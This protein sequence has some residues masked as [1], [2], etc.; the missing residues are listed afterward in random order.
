[1]SVRLPQTIDRPASKKQSQLSSPITSWLSNLSS[2]SDSVSEQKTSDHHRQSSDPCETT[3]LVQRCVIIQKDQHGFGFTVSGDRIVL[4]QSVRPGGAAMKAGVKEGDRIIKVN[5]TMVTNSSHL[6]VV[7]LIKSGAYVA[8]TLLGSSTSSVGVSGLQEDPGSLGP[9]RVIPVVPPPPPPPPPPLPQRITGPKPLQDPEVQKHA[10]QILINMLR[11]EEKELQHFQEMYS[12]NPA[13]SLLE[14][15]I[16]GARRRITQLQRK[17]Q[18]ETGVSV[19]ILQL[20]DTNPA[21]LKSSEGCHFLDSQDGDSGLDSGTERFPSLSESLLKR[22]SVLSDPGLDSPRTSP[23]IMAKMPQH[24]RRQGSDTTVLPTTEQSLDHSAKPLIIGPEEDYDP[25]YFNNECDILFQDLEKLKYRPAHLGVFLRYI[26]SQADPNPLLFYLCAEVYLQT[27]PK[28][29]RGLGKAIWAIFLEKNSPLRVKI[30]ETLQAEI[31]LRLR[32]NEDIRSALSE[33]QEATMPEIQEQ[34]QDYRTKR[35]MGLG[36]LYGENDL[37][38]LDGDPQRER[39]IA[40]RQLAALGDILSK[41][42][43]DRSVSMDF[44][45]NTYMSHAGIRLR[46]TRPSTAEKSQTLPDKDKWLPFFPKTKKQSSNTKKEKEALEDKKRNPIL[47]YI[48][49]PK[50]SSQNI[51]PGNVRNII[52]HFENNQ[53]HESPEPGLQRLSTGS[54]PEDLLESESSRSEIRLGRSESL[55]GREEMKKSRKAEN[56]PRSRS[57]VDMDAAAEATRLHQSASSSASSLSTRSLENPTPPFTPK[58]GRRSI[59]S[60]SLG[61]CTDALLPHLLEDDL[62]QLSDLEPEPDAQN[63]QHTVGKDVIAGLSQREID[64]QEVINELFV[65][66]AS[67]LRTLR[68]LD[69]IFYQRMKKENLMPR[70]ELARLFPN[71]PELIEIHNSWCEAMKKLREEGPVIN[72]ISDLMLARFDGP[73]REELQQVAAQFCS[74]QSIALELI[75]TKQRKESRFQLFMQEAESNPQ[76]RRLQLK[77]LI[78][79]E[80][81]RLTKYPLLLEN[82]IKYTDA[83]SS[84][85]YHKLC[86]ARDQCREILKYVN[87]AVKQTENRHR[88]ESYQKRLDTTSLER[89]SNPLAAE[90][91]SLDLTTRRMIHEGPLTWRISKDKTVDLHVLLLEDL[92][93]LLQKQD[94]KLLLKC[95]SKTSLGSS[96]NK[97]TFSPVLKLNAVLIRS[98]ATDK[99]AFFIICTSELGPPQI[100]ELVA[101]T[102]LDKNM[103]MELLEDAVQNATRNPSIVPNPSHLSQPVPQQPSQHSSSSTSMGLTDS[104][105]SQ[106]NGCQSEDELLPKG[107]RSQQWVN[108]K[109]QAL[110]EEPEQEGSE[111]ELVAPTSTSSL[112]GGGLGIRTRGAIHLPL[113]SPLFMEGLADSA[114]EDVENLRHLILWSL[115]PGHPI[116]SRATVEPED[117]LTPTPSVIGI[118]SHPWDPGSPG[119]LPGEMEGNDLAP[120][121]QMSSQL[122]L[123]TGELDDAAL[124]SLEHLPPR[125]RNSGIWEHPELDRDVP[126]EPLTTEAIGGYKVVRKA[127]VAGSNAVPA[128][129]ECGKSESEPPEAGGGPNAAGNCFYVSMPTGPPESNTDPSDTARSFSQHE[130]PCASPPE[131]EHRGGG[132]DEGRA[133]GTASSLALR[134]VGTIFRTIEQLTLKLHRLK[135][136]ETAHRELLKSLGAESSGGTTPVGGLSAEAVRWTESSPSPPAKEPFSSCSKDSHEQGLGP[137]TGSDSLEESPADTAISLGL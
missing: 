32:N 1:M 122:E 101:L 43:E 20:Y 66:E 50:S 21:N 135:D 7:K 131:P 112:G 57:D 39:Q 65:T 63:W 95:H 76:C 29:S 134:D 108:G 62:G 61:Y 54:F 36:S 97:Q 4:V 14:E 130:A 82:I 48:G 121:G 60:P 123:E 15:Q 128:L 55:K 125:A 10:N 27:Y 91:K 110:L 24:H 115:L 77:D 68:V 104:E 106:G 38:D 37:L 81:Q 52:Q 47:K 17:I 132:G 49:K 98:V 117:D 40:E 30:P 87:E 53:Q 113:P 6:E 51:K 64:R 137:E 92:L 41:Y 45:L 133:R 71:L 58:M 31:D 93:V 124:S 19:D 56:V 74:Y 33:A 12:R 5:G 126:E 109:H 116:E 88:L 119:Q 96:D 23:V 70:E 102:S 18:Q 26:F 120:S 34:I 44:A 127:E 89:A 105:A 100:Y 136:M 78:V 59:E 28:D 3:G 83:D 8:L 72:E 46:E 11:Q 75:K 84:S 69:L 114:L 16:E 107:D 13:S 73:A 118:T 22:N 67:H 80:M 129:P 42:E 85:E 94:E 2:L 103:W 35:T 86:R 25:G 99:R 9:S 90:F 111:E 79:S